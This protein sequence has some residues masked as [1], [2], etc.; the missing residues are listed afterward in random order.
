MPFDVELRVTPDTDTFELRLIETEAT[1]SAFDAL[2]AS[3]LRPIDDMNPLAIFVSDLA[4][5]SVRTISNNLTGTL[6]L[7]NGFTLEEFQSASHPDDIAHDEEYLRRRARLQDDQYAVFTQRMRGKNNE[8]RMVTGRTR[9]LARDSEGVPNRG[10]GVLFDT[11]EFNEIYQ[12]LNTATQR[13]ATAEQSERQ[14]L[15]RELHDVIGQ[16]LAAARVTIASLRQSPECAQVTGTLNELDS[17]VKK[18]QDEIRSLAFLLHPPDLAELGLV[19]ALDQLCLGLSGRFQIPIRFAVDCKR[20]RFEP[21][22]EYALYRVVQ[23]ALMNVHVHASANEAEV[24]VASAGP[25]LELSVTDDGVGMNCGQTYPR[26]GVGIAGMRARM[27]QIGGTLELADRDPG[28][29]VTAV[30]RVA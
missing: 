12:A 22:V 30:A 25:V 13:L 1:K 11:T 20:Q 23:E 17:L 6:S 8:W 4:N 7:R 15:G 3:L 19:D 26:P 21:D 18:S 10:L 2:A 14:R 5:R 24:R 28:L 27:S 29:I 16:E 9:V